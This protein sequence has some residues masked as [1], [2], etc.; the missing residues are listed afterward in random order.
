MEDLVT[1]R[2][3]AAMLTILGNAYRFCDGLS[4]R[5]FLKVGGLTL[6]GLS[7]PQ[8]LRAEGRPGARASH[9]A[10]I[11]VYLPGGPSHLDMFDL[12][13]EAPAGI[14]GEFKPIRTRGTGIQVCG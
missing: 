1:H 5:A 11:M 12:K 13:P 10:I 8:L 3:R 4:R 14:R 7:L 6:G 9:K 2:G